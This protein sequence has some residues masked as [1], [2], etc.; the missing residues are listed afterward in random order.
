MFYNK[1]WMMKKF[2]WKHYVYKKAQFWIIRPALFKILNSDSVEVNETYLIVLSSSAQSCS[3]PSDPSWIS[4]TSIQ[5]RHSWTLFPA[6][7]SEMPSKSWLHASPLTG[8]HDL[9]QVFDRKAEKLVPEQEV[10]SGDWSKSADRPQPR[11]TVTVCIPLGR[12]SISISVTQT[13]WI[14]KF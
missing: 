14:L 3:N 2:W 12:Q 11:W 6:K 10:D 8:M 13:S 5:L 4:P 7:S 9:V 1:I